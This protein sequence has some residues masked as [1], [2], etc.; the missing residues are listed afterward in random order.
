MNTTK[1]EGHGAVA[2]QV[3]R[4]VRPLVPKRDVV[5]L[6][7]GLERHGEDS[8][9]RTAQQ[10]REE[11]ETLRSQLAHWK[12]FGEHAEGQHAYWKK[13]AGVLRAHVEVAQ[14]AADA[15]IGQALRQTVTN[16]ELNEKD[17]AIRRL[18]SDL[19]RMLNE[20]DGPSERPAPTLLDVPHECM[21]AE[22]GVFGA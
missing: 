2:G 15:A 10:A 18:K 7:R 21:H 6:L 4:G 19:C 17:E 5:G 3:E 8:I 20:A 22:N 16:A 9:W 11:I 1:L 13:V 12:A 14:A